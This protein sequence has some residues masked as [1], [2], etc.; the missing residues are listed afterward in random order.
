MIRPS[1]RYTDP[2]GDI[3]V[4]VWLDRDEARVSV[5][6]NGRGM[7]P[8]N[9]E[10]IFVSLHAT[11]HDGEEVASDGLG[12]GLMLVRRFV[13]LH[14]GVVEVASAGLRKGS[15]FTI[16]LPAYMRRSEP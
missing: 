13:E 1:P 12:I 2:S 3:G 10:K 15:R 9:V 5:A 8:E 7:P 4:R 16:R 14:G 6:D 11:A